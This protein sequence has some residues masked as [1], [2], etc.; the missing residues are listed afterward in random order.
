PE[1]PGAPATPP[2]RRRL[3][4]R[5][6]KKQAPRCTT[7]GCTAEALRKL[8]FC[9]SHCTAQNLLAMGHDAKGAARIMAELEKVKGRHAHEAEFGVSLLEKVRRE[10][11]DMA[12]LINEK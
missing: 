6:P 11:K 5:K 7:Q 1:S 12:F 4:S 8:P 9:P 2:E 3:V 10:F